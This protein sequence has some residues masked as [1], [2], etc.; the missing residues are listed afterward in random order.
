MGTLFSIKDIS[1]TNALFSGEELFCY[2]TNFTLTGGNIIKE[3]NKTAQPTFSTA[4]GIGSDRYI[5]SYNRK[6]ATTQFTSFK[7]PNITIDLVFPYK[8]ALL[9]EKTIGGTTTKILNLKKLLHYI[10]TPKTYYVK[11]EKFLEIVAGGEYYYYST[12]GIPVVLKDYTINIDKVGNVLVSLT[13]TED[14][15]TSI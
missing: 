5:K 3:M 8:D 14:V 7:S 1:T 11:E 15:D 10:R 9:D 13:M 4:D 12:T 2:C 6:K